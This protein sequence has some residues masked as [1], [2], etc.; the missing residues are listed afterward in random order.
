MEVTLNGCGASIAG[1]PAIAKRRGV[2]GRFEA[3]WDNGIAGEF[4]APAAP[5]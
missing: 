5:S 4:R 3:V 2:T 1:L